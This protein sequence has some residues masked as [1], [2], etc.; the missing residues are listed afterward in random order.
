M[1]AKIEMRR[2]QEGVEVTLVQTGLSTK[3]DTTAGGKPTTHG[4]FYVEG[5]GMYCQLCRR[6]DIKNRQNQ[7]NKGGGGCQIY[8]YFFLGRTLH[9][10]P[11][12]EHLTF[13]HRSST[14]DDDTLAGLGNEARL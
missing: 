13:L 11:N 1:L 4:Y 7:S 14:P 8:L 6:F 2:A 9:V 12:S 5:K 10:E 3:L